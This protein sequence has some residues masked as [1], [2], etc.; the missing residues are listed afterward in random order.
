MLAAA[1]LLDGR[2]A[3]THRATLDQLGGRYPTID[4]RA[5]ERVVDEGRIVTAAGVSA[6]I[7]M[8]LVLAA[9]LAGPDVAK[10]IQLGIEYD[11]APPF[12]AG[13]PEKAP[14]EIVELVRGLERGSAR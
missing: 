11:P 9:E 7:D 5:D 1:G 3:T 10:A 6:G 4:V 13:S 14:A 8:A 12:D 2:R